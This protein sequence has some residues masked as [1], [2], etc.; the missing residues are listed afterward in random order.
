MG[1]RKSKGG[2]ASNP[3]TPTGPTSGSHKGFVKHLSSQKGGAASPTSG[4]NLPSLDP[5]KSTSKDTGGE[6]ED[7]DTRRPSSPLPRTSTRANKSVLA[8]IANIDEDLGQF[9]R[10][11]MDTK[12]EKKITK[13]QLY[14]ILVHFNAGTSSRLS[15]QKQMLISAFK[16]EV[17]PLINP[18]IIE[19]RGVS[20]VHQ[21]SGD[22]METDDVK[23]PDFDP[24]SRKTTCQMLVSAIQKKKHSIEIPRSAR[25]EGLLWLYKAYIDRDL[26]IPSNPRWTQKPRIL[27]G[28]RLDRETVEDLR[29]ALQV[30]APHI[31][32][33]S[34]AMTHPVLVCLY[35]TFILE[36][37]AS[38]SQEMIYGF[39][40]TT[41]AI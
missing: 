31:F 13:P 5:G 17:E 7:E 25:H 36:E 37:P 32:V 2:S 41:I 21:T 38:A 30:H 4:D 10:S 19:S 23:L 29:F 18:F 16:N 22:D 33:H 6:G 40:Y 27:S 28:D 11:P 3:T 8:K 15:H 26:V 1:R 34:V 9:L 12:M 35:K 20:Q 14:R 39:H 24:L